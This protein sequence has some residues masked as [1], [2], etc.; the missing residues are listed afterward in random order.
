MSHYGPFTIHCTYVS[1]IMHNNMDRT[2]LVEP[3]KLVNLL[4]DMTLKSS[5][6]FTNILL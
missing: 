3:F 1:M 4:L 5:S 6:Y 2:T